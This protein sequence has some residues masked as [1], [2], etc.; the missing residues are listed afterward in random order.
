MT[1]PQTIGITGAAGF[2]GSHLSDRLVAEGRRVIGIDDLSHG[3]MRNVEHLL[4]N[5][6]FSFRQFDCRDTLRMR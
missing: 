5:E 6:L 4:G 1:T 3:S 2:I